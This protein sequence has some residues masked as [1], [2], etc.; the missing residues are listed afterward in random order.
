MLERDDTDLSL[1]EPEIFIFFGDNV[2]DD[3]QDMKVLRRTYQKLGAKPGF[4]QLK[5]QAEW[6]V[7]WDDH[8]FC[9]NNAG[10]DYPKK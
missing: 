5:Y 6:I 8:D 3:T 4:K 9:S 2:Y 7:I 10:K 1:V